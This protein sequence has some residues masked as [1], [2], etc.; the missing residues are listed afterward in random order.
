[1]V[2]LQNKHFQLFK[3]VLLP[4][5]SKTSEEQFIKHEVLSDFK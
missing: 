1:M 2:S 5:V 4:Y 3:L